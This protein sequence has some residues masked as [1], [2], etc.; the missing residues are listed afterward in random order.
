MCHTEGFAQSAAN[1]KGHEQRG[2]VIAHIS[3]EAFAVV[4]FTVRLQSIKRALYCL[5]G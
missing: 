1:G 2:D 3:G 4:E 5:S